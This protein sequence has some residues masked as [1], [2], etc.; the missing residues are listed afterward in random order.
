M[1]F[2]ILVTPTRRSSRLFFKSSQLII[3][4]HLLPCPE[5][6]KQIPVSPSQAGDQATCSHCGQVV[7][8]PK[9][10]D[11]RQLPRAEETDSSKAAAGTTPREI[12]TPRRAGFL[13]FGLV[14]V[15]SLLVAGF[16]GI[17]WFLIEAPSTAE[18]SLESVREGY[19]TIPAAQLIREFEDMER[20]TLELTRPYDYKLQQNERRA[21]G[22]RAS[23]AGAVAA[24][25]VVGAGL[26][27][28]GT[29]RK[30]AS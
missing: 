19:A 21:W 7:P 9:L 25:A 23:I 11:L 2:K 10:G 24:I 1:L 8:I 4:M 22:T 30:S 6:E 17:R 15:A 27:T 20:L 29:K 3:V 12:S 18:T 26:T 16:C 5:C 28:V 14:A 13:L